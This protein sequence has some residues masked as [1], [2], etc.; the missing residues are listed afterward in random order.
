MC[1]NSLTGGNCL[2]E[3]IELY[4]YISKTTICIVLDLSVWLI[5]TRLE[6]EPM[7]MYNF[8]KLKQY[9]Y[10]QTSNKE[11]SVYIHITHKFESSKCI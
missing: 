2:K 4:Y 8:I 7:T 6:F 1:K 9:L 3:E 11:N 10:T 5:L